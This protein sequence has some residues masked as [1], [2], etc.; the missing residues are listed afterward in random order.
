[1]PFL[2]SVRRGAFA[3]AALIA[4]FLYFFRLDGTGVIGP[5]EPRYAAIGI[6]MAQSGNWITPVL[7]GS[8]WFEKPPLLYWMV[9]LAWKLGF[10][11]EMAAR[12]PVA[13]C[14]S[15]FLIYLWWRVRGLWN[16]SAALYA[17]AVLA[18][19]A[20][21]L[22]YG[23][24]GVT[25]LPMTVF[26]MAALIESLD[27]AQGR[28]RR[29]LI[30]GLLLGVAVLGKGLVPLVLFIPV[31]AFGWRNFSVIARLSVGVLA[32]AGPWYGLCFWLNGRIAFDELIVKHHF[33]RFTSSALQHVQPWWYYVPVLLFALF[34]WCGVGA[35]SFR[36]GG[37]PRRRLLLAYLAFGLLFFSASKNKLPG[38][39][40]PLVAPWAIL[41][42][43]QLAE[44]AAGSIA[45]ASAAFGA[46]LAP[47]FGPLLPAALAS[48]LS[49]AKGTPLPD[50]YPAL[51]LA[52]GLATLTAILDRRTLRPFAVLVVV[53]TTTL[54]VIYVKIRTFPELDRAASVR[55]F[56][57]TISD[58]DLRGCVGPIHRNLLY[59]LQFYAPYTLRPCS[60][61]SRSAGLSGRDADFRI[62][63][64]SRHR[65]VRDP[66]P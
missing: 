30:A 18:T 12:L 9:A 19:S 54:S 20:S 35:F 65:L 16:E 33:Q 2:S 47:A 52:A 51:A 14:A 21:W 49:R 3:L 61:V 13:V 29:P 11:D 28:P 10:R 66:E 27:W 25:D 32:A 34:P 6:A 23:F 64:D 41:L 50:L 59:G 56:W 39:I 60:D 4:F 48:G 5:D 31:L 22:A 62:L 45:L 38:Y 7:W 44:S 53:L 42:G 63:E 17:V 37:D 58:R 15:G 43:L 57:N 40:L 55:P 26:A 1:M 46:A 8:P 36:T 24:V